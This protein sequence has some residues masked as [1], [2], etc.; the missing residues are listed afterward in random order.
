MLTKL[1]SAITEN[2]GW[3]L[4]S[5]ALAVLMW[6]IVVNDTNPVVPKRFKVNLKILNE[7]KVIENN[8]VLLNKEA[9]LGTQVDLY[10]KGPKS[11]I[12]QLTP[13][14]QN[15]G[16]YIDL[17]PIDISHSNLL[18]EQL[19]ITVKYELPNSY[20]EVVRY[21]PDTVN[22]MLD[23]YTTQEFKI[24]LEKTGEVKDGYVSQTPEVSPETIQISGPLSVINTIT[25]VKLSVD[26]TDLTSDLNKTG[27]LI[28]SDYLGKDITN[29]QL[30]LSN[31]TADAHIQVNK[32][33]RLAIARPS[34]RGE[35]AE[36]YTITNITWE[37]EYVEVV[38]DQETIE[39]VKT[40]FL[41]P[42]SVEGLS[43][44]KT[45]TFDLRNNLPNSNLNI[46]NFAPHTATVKIDVEKEVVKDIE[47]N[48]ES[49]LIFGTQLQTK[50]LQNNVKLSIKGIESAFKPDSVSLAID[51][52]GL[53]PGM[54]SVPISVDLSKG[55]SLASNIP[56]IDI[57]ILAE[58]E[59]SLE[60][61]EE[62]VLSAESEQAET[63]PP[64]EQSEES[65]QL[66]QPEADE[67][68]QQET[69]V[70]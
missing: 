22:I 9:I 57:Q 3:K 8:Y 26:L 69:S 6:F 63:K 27:K 39:S 28:V 55:I 42:I 65:E 50:F 34:I 51:L 20:C 24:T 21:T 12:D 23:K 31:T 46:K 64:L 33:G 1:N 37:P 5:I 61:L 7:E 35:V 45:Y 4:V 30:I 29:K 66:G 49:I 19:P 68:I 53:E 14:Q 32:L 25:S 52:T 11:I 47:Y 43:E 16:A 36:G 59:H 17:K 60:N 44:T 40:I 48:T 15:F 38:G 10:I 13:N 56:Q 54:H 67:E 18:G 62:E 2:I 70:E 58:D 41:D